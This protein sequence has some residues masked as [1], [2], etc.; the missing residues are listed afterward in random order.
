MDILGRFYTSNIISNL[1]VDNFESKSP[2]KILDLGLGDASLSIAAYSKWDTAKYFGTEIEK[3]K[4]EILNKNLSFIKVF[5][6]DT[7]NPNTSKRLQIKF[8]QIDVAICNPPYIKVENKS[9][10]REL[11]Q[12]IGC[13]NFNKLKRIT[14][15]IVF[16]AHN[17][18]LL[19]RK[20]ELGIIVSD[21]LITGKD[22][23]IFRETIFENFNVK[24]IIQLPDNVF[25]KTEARTHIIFISKT[26]SKSRNCKLLISSAEGILSDEIIIENKKL[27]QRMD[28]HFHKTIISIPTKLKTLSNIGAKIRRGKYSYKELRL[29]NTKYFHSTDFKHHN[30]QLSFKISKNDDLID[31]MAIK[32]DILMCRVGKRIVGRFAVIKSGAIVHSDCIYKITVPLEYLDSVIDSLNSIEGKTW[33][34]AYVH[35]VCSQVLSKSDLENFPLFQFTADEKDL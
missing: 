23:K 27:S 9:Q 7:L 2:K 8:G 31:L 24:R 25:N 22:F 10:Y 4:V 11:F 35:G 21:S 18:K 32:G 1:L 19:K 13:D 15:E 28:Y 5:N 26:K 29:S 34:S 3:H 6:Y 12:E 33:I 30:D 16:F 20:G 14:S 17:V